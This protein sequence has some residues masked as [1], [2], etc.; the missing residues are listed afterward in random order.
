[1]FSARYGLNGPIKQ[2]Q[3]T[4]EVPQRPSLHLVTISSHALQPHDGRIQCLAN[5]NRECFYLPTLTFCSF[6]DNV[7]MTVMKSVSEKKSRGHRM[8]MIIKSK[9]SYINGH[10]P[11]HCSM[12]DMTCE[13]VCAVRM[14]RNDQHKRPQGFSSN[15]LMSV[16]NLSPLGH[17]DH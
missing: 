2:I 5:R 13:S 7:E 14:H 15:F 8:S 4:G 11:Y 16:P 1:M 9:Q 12:H 6:L 10:L 3:S 17:T